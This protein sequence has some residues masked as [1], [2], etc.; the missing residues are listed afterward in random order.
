MATPLKIKALSISDGTTKANSLVQSLELHPLGIKGDSHAGANGRQI[1]LLSQ[2]DIDSYSQKTGLK[3][4]KGELGENIIVNNF[5]TEDVLPLD[6]FFTNE[7]S[8]VVTQKG[9]KCKDKACTSET[10]SP[11]HA[12]SIFGKVMT[13]GILNKHDVLYYK[14]YVYKF[15]VITISDRAYNGDYADKSGPAIFNAIK[16]YFKVSPRKTEITSTIVPDEVEAIQAAIKK[17]TSSADFIFTTGGTGI[18]TRDVTP[19]ALSP[20]FDKNI[21]SIMEYV[22]FKYAPQFP[23]ALL[24]RSIAGTIDQTA[25]YAM[26]GSPKAVLEYMDEILPTLDHTLRMLKGVDNH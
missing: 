5:N 1:C 4:S 23:N 9:S 18:S 6:T 12:K 8:F 2:F 24:S 19:E 22:K 10:D 13:N 26:P 16:D 14:P 17:A 15:N 7:I 25:V 21:S 11:M 20:L 3:I